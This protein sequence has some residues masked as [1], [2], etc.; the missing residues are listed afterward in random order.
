MFDLQPAKLLLTLHFPE[1]PRLFKKP[2]AF[3]PARTSDAFADLAPHTL[4]VLRPKGFLTPGAPWSARCLGVETRGGVRPRPFSRSSHLSLSP[5]LPRTRRCTAVSAGGAEY[6]A[7]RSEAL[8][9]GATGLP[10]AGCSPVLLGQEERSRE[11]GSVSLEKMLRTGLS[12]LRSS[13]RGSGH[14]RCLGGAEAERGFAVGPSL[15]AELGRNS[16][17]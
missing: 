16:P 15:C 9:A 17:L 1:L 2:F 4:H 3:T 7:P 10:S 8:R 5:D 6:R 13:G 12:L 11:P 14:E